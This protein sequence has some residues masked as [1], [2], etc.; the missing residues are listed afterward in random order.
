M[1]ASRLHFA[2]SPDVKVQL[3]Q[4]RNFNF[5]PSRITASPKAD[6]QLHLATPPC[7]RVLRLP[8]GDETKVCYVA[9]FDRVICIRSLLRSP[10]GTQSQTART[11]RRA[12]LRTPRVC[13]QSAPSGVKSFDP[14]P[15]QTP[16]V[17]DQSA[18]KF[19]LSRPR[20]LLQ[21]H[22]VCDQGAPAS[23][24]TLTHTELQ[25]PCVCDQGA[26]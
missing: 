1:H 26:P 25:T 16:H 19:S 17:C 9:Y 3:H 5:T 12:P 8:C 11:L 18:G 21:T 6:I 20:E 22:H 13:D 14:S 4:M 24:Q 10:S 7:L 23:N 2:T 15:L